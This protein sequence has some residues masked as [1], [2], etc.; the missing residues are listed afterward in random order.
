MTKLVCYIKY[1]IKS[2]K[3]CFFLS[4]I[5]SLARVTIYILFELLQL[6]LRNN[7]RFALNMFLQG[8]A[9]IP[10]RRMSVCVNYARDI[11]TRNIIWTHGIKLDNNQ[12]IK[13]L[14]CYQGTNWQS[15][16]RACMII[17]LRAEY[18]SIVFLNK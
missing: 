3:E 17:N 2:E 12:I 8:F 9:I 1:I 7:Y 15:Y 13:R 5:L 18:S 16:L 10:G 11:N 4:S 6:L 14:N